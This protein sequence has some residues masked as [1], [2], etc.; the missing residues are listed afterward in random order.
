M[1]W[2]MGIWSGGIQEK[3]NRYEELQVLL[4]AL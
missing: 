4:K 1:S 3:G 2:Y